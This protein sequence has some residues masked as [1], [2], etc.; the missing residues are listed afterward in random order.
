MACIIALGGVGVYHMNHEVLY[1]DIVAFMPF[2]SVVKWRNGLLRIHQ[3]V[4][5]F[6]PHACP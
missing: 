3:Y 4:Q 5:L 6:R 1:Q 2:V